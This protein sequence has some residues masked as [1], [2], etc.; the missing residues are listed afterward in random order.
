MNARREADTV[1]VFGL[2]N[3]AGEALLRLPA[4][5]RWSVAVRRIGLAPERRAPVF[6]RIGESVTARFTLRAAPFQLPGA[7]VVAASGSCPG[8]DGGVM[9]VSALWDQVTLALQ[10]S[11]LAADEG[12]GSTVLRS[13]ASDRE[14]DLDLRV[15][16]ET[17]LQ[18]RRGVG[19]PYAA[20]HPDSLVL[21]G[22]VRS[23]ADRT[24][25]YFAPDERSLL[26]ESF[27]RTHCFDTPPRDA[28]PG[29]AELRFRPAPTRRAPDVA[30]SA[31]VDAATG[32]LQRISFRFVNADSL[33]PSGTKHAGG[34]VRFDRLPDDTWYV[35]AWSIRMPRMLRVTWSRVPRLTG[36]HEVAGA[37]DTLAT[38]TTA[39]VTV[40]RTAAPPRAALNATKPGGAPPNALPTGDKVIVGGKLIVET[41]TAAARRRRE[42]R[43]EFAAR[44]QAGVGVFVDSTELAVGQP[45]L[46]RLALVRPI[47]L[48]VVP[49]DV[50]PPPRDDDPDLAD[51]WV[52]GAVVPVMPVVSG[53]EPGADCLVKLFLDGERTTSTR[54]HAL[55]S[56][57][58]AALEFYQRPRDVP[59]GYRRG[60]NRCGTVLLWSR[61]HH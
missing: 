59:D 55:S 29:V 17:P 19:R 10:G 13:V 27:L 2:T 28:E 26:S 61:E 35:A 33:F 31:F 9:R 37:V 5:G 7:R 6:V 24:L 16:S 21:H 11:A 47:R 8:T 39:V 18:V 15:L 43:T 32:A 25:Q 4:E 45:V 44:R 1:D 60:G 54:M 30:G 34:E 36:Y 14:L 52:A 57:A 12:A 58:L 3:A 23:D 42:W 41:T 50:P 22:Y 38:N 48:F 49:A 56:D 46:Q 20:L 53:G 40:T 51:S